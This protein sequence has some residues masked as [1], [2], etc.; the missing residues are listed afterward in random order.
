MARQETARY[1]LTSRGTPRISP[2]KM[3][4]IKKANLEKARIAAK[5]N[6]EARQADPNYVPSR[7]SYRPRAPKQNGVKIDLA[8][9]R[10][11]VGN[12]VADKVYQ[13]YLNE[14]NPPVEITE[15]QLDAAKR[16]VRGEIVGKGIAAVW[17][18]VRR[19]F[20]LHDLDHKRFQNWVLE[21]ELVTIVEDADAE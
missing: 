19:Y 13:E 10:K 21:T 3:Q 7:K 14:L 9:L 20:Q 8:V 17:P 18:V 4:E 6:K 16:Y 12:E 1:G 15:S 5:R 2:A 11:V